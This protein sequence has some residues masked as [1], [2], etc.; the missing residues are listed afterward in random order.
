M[1]AG[2]PQAEPLPP[3]PMEEAAPPAARSRRALQ[4]AGALLGVGL[5]LWLAV[6]LPPPGAVP[7][8]PLGTPRASLPLESFPITLVPGGQEVAPPWQRPD[9]DGGAAPEAAATPAPVARAT[10]PRETRVKTPAKAPAPPKQ[11]GSTA[12]K[13]GAAVIGCALSTGCPGPATT[14]SV[15]PTSPPPAECPP[16]AARTMEELGLLYAGSSK[17]GWI[18]GAGR[19]V[20]VRPGPVTLRLSKEEGSWGKL[21]EGTMFSGEQLFGERRVHG[22]FTQAHTPEG[23]SYVV[24]LELKSG[25][26]WGWEKLEVHGQDTAVIDN[27]GVLWPVESFGDEWKYEEREKR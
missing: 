2:E 11:A 4:A 15:R 27:G 22:R 9:G 13:V 18:P 5:G 19:R 26:D 12:R 17:H 21:P 16:E 10:L 20:T 23:K 3:P 14:A 25:P 7:T 8:P 24:C 6:H 1:G